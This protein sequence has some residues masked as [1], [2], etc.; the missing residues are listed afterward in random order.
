MFLRQQS[1]HYNATVQIDSKATTGVLQT[2][3]VAAS[4]KGEWN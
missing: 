3:L 2:V 4:E 1:G